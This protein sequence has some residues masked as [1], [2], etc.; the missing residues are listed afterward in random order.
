MEQQ[1]K[2]ITETGAVGLKGVRNED[3]YPTQIQLSDEQLNYI[4]ALSDA[5]AYRNYSVSQGHIGYEGIEDPSIYIPVK[6][7][8]DYGDSKYDDRPLFNATQE[9]VNDIRAYSQSWFKKIQN[10]LTKGVIL[11]GTT[12]LDGTVGFVTGL[13]TTPEKGLAGLYDNPFSQA[14]AKINE[15]SEEALPNY[16]TTEQANAAWYNPVN[17][18]SANFLGDKF[19]KNIGFAVGAFYS[20]GVYTGALK[21]ARLPKLVSTITKSTRAANMIN[22]SIGATISA[23][24]EGRIEALNGANEFEK[25]MKASLQ[26]QY[27]QSLQEIEQY[28]GTPMYNQLKAQADNAYQ[29]SLIQLQKEK[30]D[31][32]NTILKANVPL[33]TASNILQWGK[34]FANGFKTARRTTNIVGNLQKGYST[35]MSKKKGIMR[36]ALNPLSEGIEESSQSIITQTSDIKNTSDL[37]NFYRAKIDPEAE[38]QTLDYMNAF[39]QALTDTLSDPASGEEFFLGFLTG[40]LGI[41]RF[42][43]I[44]SNGKFRSPITIDGGFRGEYKHYKEKMDREQQI[45]DYLN[46]R[47][48]SPEFKNYYRGYIRHRKLQNEMDEATLNGNEFD[49]RNSEYAQMISDISMFDNAGKLQDLTDLINTVY[50]ISDENLQA[51]VEGTTSIVTDNEGNQ[52]SIGPFVDDKGNSILSTESGK[53]EMIEKITKRKD[54][55]LNAIKNYRKIKDSIDINTDEALTDDQLEE[56][57]YFK[58]QLGNWIDRFNTLNSEVSPTLTKVSNSLSRMYDAAERG[59]YTDGIL[60]K[61]E[62]KHFNDSVQRLLEAFSINK[63]AGETITNNI[64]KKDI[65]SVNKFIEENDLL[66]PD[67]AEQ[68][69]AKLGDMY[70]ILTGVV[71]YRAKLKEYLETPSKQKEDHEK[72]DKEVE[73]QSTSK[74]K[75]A[76]KKSLSSATNL[77]E[78]R[79]SLNNSDDSFEDKTK[80]INELNEEKNPI[81]QNYKQLE[82]YYTRLLSKIDSS[83][84]DETAKQ[85]ALKL[86]KDQYDNA[87]Q[88]DQLL[89]ESSI[90][91]TDPTSLDEISSSEEE[92]INRHRIA[93]YAVQKAIND[94][95]G[96]DKFKEN[97]AKPAQTK[98]EETSENFES[99]PNREDLEKGTK[100]AAFG[101]DGQLIKSSEEEQIPVGNITNEE[102]LDE[103]KEYKEELLP[104]EGKT[105]KW[106]RP[107]IP[108]LHI[109]A[110]KEGDFR[111][112]NIVASERNP[113]T[114][115]DTIYNYLK[116]AGTFDYINSGKLKVDTEIGFM[117]DPLFEEE[118]KK[119][120]W[121]KGPTIFLIDNTTNQ[122]V[123]SLDEAQ[124]SVA[125]YEGLSDLRNNITKEYENRENKEGNFIATPKT[126]VSQILLGKIP[127]SQESKSLSEIP[128]V[129]EEGRKPIFG[130]IKNGMLVTNDAIKDSDIIKPLDIRNKEGRLYLL[131]PNAK[132][133]YS[134]ASVR[135][136]HFNKNEFNPKDVTIQNTPIFKNIDRAIDSIVNSENQDQINEAVK[137]LSNFIYTKDVFIEIKDTKN[138]PALKIDRYI[139][140]DK[141]NYISEKREGKEERKKETSFIS[142]DNN[143]EDIKDKLY[144]KLLSFN[145]PI[146]VS[147]NRLNDPNYNKM[148]INSGI[149][150]SNLR[151][152]RVIGSWFVTDY[153][154]KEGKA[155]RADIIPNKKPESTVQKNTVNGK[156][157]VVPGT[158][159]T[160]NNTSLNVDLTTNTIYDNKGNIVNPQ[161]SQLILDVAWAQSNYGIATESTNMID[162]KV[163]TPKGKVLD[164]TTQTYLSEQEA[165]KIK[166]QINDRKSVGKS[167]SEK[168]LA[169]IA[170]NQQKVDKTKTDSESYY[171]LE[172]DGQYHAYDR[173]H[174][175]LGNNS[176]D[177]KESL[178]GQRALEAGTLV[179]NII[180]TFFTSNEAIQKPSGMTQEAF[181]KL[182]NTLAEIRS[183]IEERGERFLTNNIVL[184]HKYSDG[185]RVAG[186]VDI[187]AIDKDGNF[188][189]YDIKT[190]KYSF[191]DFKNNQE[192]TTNYFRNKASWQRMS[193]E[194]YYTL[195]LS[196]YKNL[197]ESQYN[198]S[199]TTLAIMPFVLSYNENE[200]TSVKRENGIPVTYNPMTSVPLEKSS[201]QS[202]TN[203]SNKES[204]DK[205]R[206]I[207]T[208]ASLETL[209]P[210][211]QIVPEA[212][213]EGLN[214]FVGYYQL[215]DTIYKG[216]ISPLSIVNSIPI[217][218]TKIPVM[219]KGLSGKD[220]YVAYSTY[221]LVF[222]N[223]KAVKISENPGTDQDNI[224]VIK[225]ALNK[226]ADKLPKYANEET[227]LTQFITD[228]DNNFNT[229][230]NSIIQKSQESKSDS[231][232]DRVLNDPKLKSVVDK[233]NTFKEDKESY[234]EVVATLTDPRL[235]NLDVIDI[236]DNPANK[237]L[238]RIPGSFVGYFARKDKIYKGY[239]VLLHYDKLDGNN[240]RRVANGLITIFREKSATG[241]EENWVSAID[242]RYDMNIGAS[243]IFVVTDNDI[244]K[245]IDEYFF[246]EYSTMRDNWIHQGNDALIDVKYNSP[247]KSY[248]DALDKETTSENLQN[249]PVKVSPKPL[250]SFEA[251]QAIKNQDIDPE[252]DDELKLKQVNSEEI[253]IW[254]DEKELKWL[255][256]VLPQVTRENRVTLV[257][258]LINVANKGIQAWGQFSNGIITLSDIAAKGTTYHEAFHLVF[259]SFLTNREKELLFE[260]ARQLYGDKSILELEEDMAE[261]FREYMVTQENKGFGRGLLDFFKEL[262][263]KV[264]NWKYLKPSLN[265]YY[266]MINEGRYSNNM[267]KSSQINKAKYE[268][269]EYSKEEQAILINESLLNDATNFL[270]NFGITIND[271]KNYEGELPLFDALNRILNIRSSNDIA[272][273]LGEA[274]AF[275]MQYDP[276]IREMISVLKTGSKSA[277]V[278]YNFYKPF[279]L[280]I[281]NYLYK[282]KTDKSKY[283]RYLGEE[284]SKRLKDFYNLKPINE[285]DVSL[286]KIISEFFKKLNPFYLYKIK[287]ISNIVAPIIRNI[288]NN[289]AS[290]IINNYIK[291]GTTLKSEKVDIDKALLEN[292][293]EESIIS[294]LSSKGIALAGGASI[295]AQGTLYRPIENPLHDIDFNAVGESRDSIEHILSDKYNWELINTIKSK[296]KED[297]TTLTYLIMDRDFIQK[298]EIGNIAVYTIYDKNTRKKLGTRTGSELVLEEGV[299][300]KLLDF[301]IGKDNKDFD[302]I[303]II[304]NGKSYLFA[305]YRNAMKFKIN[306]AREKDI[307]DYNRF[308]PNTFN[309]YF[310]TSLQELKQ[311]KITTDII[312]LLNKNKVLKQ[313]I[314][315]KY[316]KSL[317]N[318]NENLLRKEIIEGYKSML[319]DNKFYKQNKKEIDKLI[320]SVQSILSKQS[321]DWS[322]LNKENKNMLQEL[323]WTEQRFNSVSQREREQAVKCLGY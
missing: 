148:L 198:A 196:S 118:M 304:L 319:N 23:V 190:S 132:G 252:L 298:R 249:N 38:E 283:L 14:M 24:N 166:K 162:N 73:K 223:G 265:N 168:I 271:I 53:Q 74:K 92:M 4:N 95:K 278:K 207:I 243:T 157:S 292:P 9:E 111:P 268:E 129:S 277:L 52:S 247:I 299:K 116:N 317:E 290:F 256:K 100:L 59:L 240:N 171:I 188:K 180:R 267:F 151:E 286:W 186:E 282:Y 69:S 10:G 43:S 204:R 19:L 279:R 205:N 259:N 7:N 211:S 173:V 280:E 57:V 227:V 201:Q 121:Y 253:E 8:I 141:G 251:E 16:Y 33:L 308:I 311:N 189:I 172:D 72:V 90:Y 248:L 160:F 224:A 153:I 36:A 98:K 152:A 293:Y 321:N 260:E 140:D 217:Y 26:N 3:L 241:K 114:N 169:E 213:I 177:N 71:A 322:T 313:Y 133:K 194:Q 145:L 77:Q 262:F 187:L 232:I 214:S 47:I 276:N 301:F 42:R 323:G 128:Y 291:P 179:D 32:G 88:L 106:Y 117:I 222:T 41:P 44:R 266:R 84:L 274:I 195:Q 203:I 165:D 134:T 65:D 176:A 11:A 150:T 146:Q 184:F 127:Y 18:F 289:D 63:D 60:S 112:F 156:E 27:T 29:E 64:N 61:K 231:K 192:T 35:T 136:K 300:G 263:V 230:T 297:K 110:S 93:Q 302:N 99:L 119:N 312:K 1:I 109:Q 303:S 17:L 51:I 193:S 115:F 83:S 76:L 159:I 139:R 130:I 306:V 238:S 273:G 288:K 154:N 264:T 281:S 104:Q 284:I 40:G 272:D 80:V 122:I 221:Y 199:I 149:L 143:K 28:R 62:T 258:G 307:W 94:V 107:A 209:L 2:D 155:E 126:R 167:N 101:A 316:D 175:R 294:Y 310:K 315:E 55:V 219:S 314:K 67:T 102:L 46:Q 147:I 164:R 48:Q 234:L 226:Y 191:H 120:S 305:D 257:N 244:N 163:I 235:E 236:T 58:S 123:G 103:S 20:G 285:K 45:V 220:N 178:Y 245:A 210:E 242:S 255:D 37:N 85:D 108:E 113:N 287:A 22:T 54:A 174:K 161:D 225:E 237:Q 15:W 13:L 233:I 87:E 261:G 202:S 158:Q 270:S 218:L 39:S 185:T 49:Y 215:N 137:L 12:F 228:T 89:D 82:S 197:F 320:D 135:V 296:N 97:F 309:N 75:K 239:I 105:N 295:A 144:E 79:N 68:F 206:S 183:S 96:D 25:N 124:H 86:L 131:I 70:K 34:L 66:D 318:I 5:A 142:L 254:D 216:Y 208:N 56:L 269:G 246:G 30:A 181:D 250:K 31:V 81:A 78:F 50:D 182:I 6:S 138:G 125:R 212:K 91:I 275:M 229:D 170:L 200:I 21:L